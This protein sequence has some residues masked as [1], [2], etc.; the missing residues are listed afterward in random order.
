MAERDATRAIRTIRWTGAPVTSGFK[1]HA[2]SVMN[3]CRGH[4]ILPFAP[5]VHRSAAGA[6]ANT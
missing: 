2:N 1:R 6:F 4:A 5:N 3:T